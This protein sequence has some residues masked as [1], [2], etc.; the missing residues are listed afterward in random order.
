VN[1]GKLIPALTSLRFFA[2][3]AVVAIHGVGLWNFELSPFL[4]QFAAIG[5]SFF[6]V[7][8]GF[9]LIWNYSNL[10]K[11]GIFRF[12]TKR[13][14]RI[15]PTH[16]LVTGLYALSSWN[17]VSGFAVAS[18]GK[19]WLLVLMMNLCLLQSWIPIPAD[20]FSYNGPSWSVS[21]EIFFYLMFPLL[22]FTLKKSRS[23]L[24]AISFSIVIVSIFIGGFFHP[25][26][27]VQ[28]PPIW[29]QPTMNGFIQFSP[30]NR[31][32]EFC[33]GMVVGSFALV[34]N[35]KKQTLESSQNT[36]TKVRICEAIS[37]V[38]FILFIHFGQ[39][40]RIM[41]IIGVMY[42]SDSGGLWMVMSGSCFVVALLIYAVSAQESL[43]NIVFNYKPFIILGEASFALYLVHVPFK[44]YLWQHP[45]VISHFSDP[46]KVT[47]YFCGSIFLSLLIWKFW[48]IPVRKITL[49]IIKKYI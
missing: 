30:I 41:N 1:N 13:F 8:S 40:P 47:I 38:I 34:R 15:Y 32:F 14:L 48:E 37:I 27:S 3:L 42:I 39:L 31:V 11:K 24:L 26:P 49:Q 2:A 35:S 28:T 9:I 22:L 20:Y 16:W 10:E 36:K 17:F 21:C 43:T 25:H 44:M 45:K 5:V 4:Q 19:W 46:L 29:W 7:L 18:L 6:F 23:L 12:Y 33:I